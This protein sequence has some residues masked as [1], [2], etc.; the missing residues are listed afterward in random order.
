MAH[1][2][3]LKK[4]FQF[5]LHQ[6]MEYFMTSS[7]STSLARAEYKSHLLVLLRSTLKVLCHKTVRFLALKDTYNTSHLVNLDS[8]LVEEC[9]IEDGTPFVQALAQLLS[10]RNIKSIVT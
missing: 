2:S 1:E 5:F 4:C 10:D 3:E 9:R 7:M 6:I 8:L